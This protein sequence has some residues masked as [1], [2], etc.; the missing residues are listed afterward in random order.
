MEHAPIAR[1]VRRCTRRHWLRLAAAGVAV[2]S[3]SGWIETLAA[4]AAAP[5]AAAASRASCSG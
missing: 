4:D 3:T 5:S 1:G 2:A